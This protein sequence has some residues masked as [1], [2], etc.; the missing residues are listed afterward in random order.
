MNL[1][2]K[3]IALSLYVTIFIV[4]LA[5]LG[6][7]WYFTRSFATIKVFPVV[8]TVRIDGKIYKT[9]NGTIKTILEPGVHEVVVEAPDSIGTSQK[10]DLGRGSNKEVSVA[11]AEM[12]KPIKIASDAKMTSRGNDFN[13]FYYLGENSR[14][15]FRVKLGIDDKTGEI[16]TL[17]HRSITDPKLSS[18]KEIAWSPSGQLALFRKNNND[19]NLFDF[20]KYDFVNQTERLWGKN[21]GSMAWAP[22]DS[23]IAY[24]YNPGTGEESLI[25]SNLGNTDMTR[26]ADF[27]AYNINNPILHW[28]P[29]S[30]WLLVIPRNSDYATNKIYLFNAYARSIKEFTAEGDQL[31]AS[32]SPDSNK[33]LF[34]TYQKDPSS[35]IPGTLS[36]MDKDGQNLKNLNLRADL[37]KIVWANDSKHIVVSTYNPDLKH[38]EIFRF[39]TDTGEKAGFILRNLGDITINNLVLSDDEKMV[40]YE[41]KDGVYAVKVN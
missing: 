39:N 17:E 36:I 31:D 12:P 8:A 30:E 11:L 1:E 32:F 14:T 21:I 25:L 3:K 9:Q 19:I 22:D 5:I 26:V 16:K 38:D 13:S 35:S 34:S 27:G 37:S 10:V 20:A 6:A 23:E 18:N 41:T 40:I 15:L 4:V 2:L 28:S 33:V 7:I 24:Y 29:D